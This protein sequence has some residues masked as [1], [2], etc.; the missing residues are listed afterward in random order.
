[1]L[2]SR[3]L[4][5]F[6]VYI[7]S[8]FSLYYLVYSDHSR[9]TLM[10]YAINLLGCVF[11]LVFNIVIC[12]FQI[13]FET[14][15]EAVLEEIT[16]CRFFFSILQECINLGCDNTEGRH[17]HVISDC[18]GLACHLHVGETFSPQRL[19]MFIFI[20]KLSKELLN[21]FGRRINQFTDCKSKARSIIAYAE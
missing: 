4:R 5:L 20:E 15:L 18:Q 16:L 12:S 13:A 7:I 3:F 17:T 9:K 14:H 21:I 2:A 6:F 11:D 8:N 19:K 10:F 1:M